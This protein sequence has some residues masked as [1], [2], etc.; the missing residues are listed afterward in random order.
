M[1]QTV[2]AGSEQKGTSHTV[3]N[4]VTLNHNEAFVR[5]TSSRRILKPN[6]VILLDRKARS[7]ALPRALP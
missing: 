5:I 4:P 3:N 6:K 1:E 2:D 7:L